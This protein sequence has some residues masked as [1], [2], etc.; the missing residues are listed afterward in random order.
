MKIKGLV[1][2]MALL[3]LVGCTPKEEVVDPAVIEAGGSS[4]GI[5]RLQI[6]TT[7]QPE[8][9]T[10]LARQYVA[11]LGATNLRFK[12]VSF[13]DRDELETFLAD[14]LPTENGPDVIYIDGDWVAR[15]THKLMP[16]EGDES[17]NPVNFRNTFVQSAQQLLVRDEKIWGVPLGV[18]SLGLFYNDA[19]IQDRLPS[20][21]LPGQT[22]EEFQTDVIALTKTD[23][24]FSRFA[25]AAAA[26][27]R[28][29]NVTYGFEILENIFL[30]SGVSF[31]TADG[32]EINFDKI[33]GSR[34][35]RS[36][37]FGEEALDFFTS[38]ADDR[39]RHYT[40][41]EFVAPANQ[42]WADYTEFLKGNV[43]MVFGYTRDFARLKA[44]RAEL[45]Q[46]RQTVIPEGDIRVS[47]LPQMQDP[48]TT[49]TRQVVAKVHSLVVPQT[50]E[51]PEAA[52]GFL[53]FAINKDNLQ[54]WHEK[55]QLPTPRVDMLTDQEATPYIGVFVRQ[56]K[57]A[58]GVTS[59]IDK[60]LI[61][62]AL[63]ASVEN[64]QSR[65]WSVL[66]GLQRAA[67]TLNTYWRNWQIKQ[68]E[69]TN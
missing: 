15:N 43:S 53:K 46:K 7:E 34:N 38:F 57:F 20:R 47:F 12:V 31:F 3:L 6:W 54:T 68:R 36:E 69:I 64:V 24:S 39:F 27:G 18:D 65:K 16:A 8:F 28:L 59:P 30:Q 41:N 56:A 33:Q 61:A 37:N 45:Q 48:R 29:D 2:A 13:T 52:W 14:Y 19:H 9:F 35:G 23:N 55:T 62:E 60:S 11:S 21:N 66:Q 22:W 17:F 25:F 44:M 26:L 42:S 58:E 1:L 32:T 50:S 5:A 63:A 4:D 10:A 49:P 40:W 51:F 67:L